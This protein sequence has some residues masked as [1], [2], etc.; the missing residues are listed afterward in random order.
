MILQLKLQIGSTVIIAV[1]FFRR[2]TSALVFF[3]FSPLE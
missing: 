1:P 2:T 3:A